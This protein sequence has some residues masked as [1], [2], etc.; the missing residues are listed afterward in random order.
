MHG[1]LGPWMCA[2]KKKGTKCRVV[3]TC[4]CVPLCVSVRKKK[5]TKLQR[6]IL[7]VSVAMSMGVRKKKEGTR[8]RVVFTCIGRFVCGC[9]RGRVTAMSP[10]TSH[11]RQNDDISLSALKAIHG[12]HLEMIVGCVG[13]DG[14]DGG[15]DGGR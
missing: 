14:C 12:G 6:F 5:R 10:H 15:C 2:K 8:Y 4:V 7:P 9:A 1:S 3:F 11:G 13:D